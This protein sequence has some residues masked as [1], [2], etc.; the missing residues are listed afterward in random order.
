M[1]TDPVAVSVTALCQHPF[2][3]IAVVV[4]YGGWMGRCIERGV[5]VM[6][7]I[8]CDT[9]AVD[10]FPPVI[11]GQRIVPDNAVVSVARTSVK[12]NVIAQ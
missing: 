3:Y 5:R 4:S 10:N 11:G 1:V 12:P 9:V 7:I 6:S 8:V 2:G